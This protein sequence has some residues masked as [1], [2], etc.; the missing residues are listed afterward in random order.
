MREWGWLWADELIWFK[1][2]GFPGRWRGR[3]RDGF[4]RLLHFT[5]QTEYNFY[6]EAVKVPRRWFGKERP[7]KDSENGNNYTASIRKS[8]DL[9]DG[10]LAFPS[11]VVE[12]ALAQNQFDSSVWHPATFP[13]RLP[14]FFID[15]FTVEGDLVLDPFVGSGTTVIQAYRMN[16]RAIGLEIKPEYAH[17]A[18]KLVQ[19]QPKFL[20]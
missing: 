12:V 11:N 19:A 15:L 5:R 6:D 14:K 7:R 1:R 2:N 20:L 16:R 3:L 9:W 4:E 18:G 13:H 17:R 8:R 10:K